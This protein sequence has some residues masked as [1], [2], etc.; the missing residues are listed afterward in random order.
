[1]KSTQDSVGSCGSATFL[2]GASPLGD[3]VRL[4]APWRLFFSP[5]PHGLD[6][7][8]RGRPRHGKR[9]GT[10]TTFCRSATSPPLSFFAIARILNA[11][12][13]ADQRTAGASPQ[14]TIAPRSILALWKWETDQKCRVWRNKKWSLWFFATRWVHGKNDAGLT[15]LTLG[16]AV[17]AVVVTGTSWSL[18]F[19]SSSV[20][21]VPVLSSII[22]PRDEQQS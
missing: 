22:H 16:G 7:P 4:G 20:G 15:A 8:R 5:A 14:I 10:T 19:F 21:T 9:Q 11:P 1:M 6:L 3:G 18:W 2:V 17:L 12:L 13:R